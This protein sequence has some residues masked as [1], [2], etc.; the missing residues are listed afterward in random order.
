MAALASYA[1]M[2]WQ[3]NQAS[4]RDPDLQSDTDKDLW[5]LEQDQNQCLLHTESSAKTRVRPMGG[6]HCHAAIDQIAMIIKF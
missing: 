2:P 1:P 3:L 6:F 5:T 4:K